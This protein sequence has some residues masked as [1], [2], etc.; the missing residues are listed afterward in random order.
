MK[1]ILAL[2]LSVLMVLSFAACGGDKKD[3]SEGGEK[4]DKLPE[5]NAQAV[6]ADTD[7]YYIEITGM[8]DSFLGTELSVSL[9]NRMD[10]ACVFSLDS[11][12]VN[13]VECT[14]LMYVEV[15]AGKKATDTITVFDDDLEMIGMSEYT[16]MQFVFSVSDTEYA[17][18]DSFEFG[19]YP[20]GEENASKFVRE[21]KSSDVVVMDNEYVTVTMID[22]KD[23]EFLGYS[24][25]FYVENKTDETLSLSA[26]GVSVNDIMTEPYFF[27][28]VNAG[29]NAVV[30]MNWSDLDEKSITDVEKIEF[31]LSA[32]NGDDWFADPYAVETI[33]LNP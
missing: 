21:E 17:E 27:V 7:D 31:E 19:F 9:E 3:A 18:L 29:C 2:L 8:E 13:G 15:E 16:D 26:D 32:T 20:Y 10:E 6:V 14:C 33:V 5:M 23:D 30:D 25:Y 1:K 22:A 24:V 28:Y 11:L 12:V 4:K